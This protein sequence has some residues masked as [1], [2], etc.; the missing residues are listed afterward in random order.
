M[1]QNCSLFF[2]AQNLLLA[3][4]YV[5]D[6]QYNRNIPFETSPQSI[7]LVYFNLWHEKLFCCF[8]GMDWQPIKQPSA[9]YGQSLSNSLY[10]KQPTRGWRK[11]N[12]PIYGRVYCFWQLPPKNI[13]LCCSHQLHYLPAVCMLVGQFPSTIQTHTGRLIVLHPTLAPL[14]KLI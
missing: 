12:R 1:S 4:A 3:A 5:Y 8:T 13:M 11:E 10:S 6:A 9:L 2:S 7:R 14:C